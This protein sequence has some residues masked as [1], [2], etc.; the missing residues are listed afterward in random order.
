MH[1]WIGT[2]R[3]KLMSAL[4]FQ[5]SGFGPR[6]MWTGSMWNFYDNVAWFCGSSAWFGGENCRAEV[7]FIGQWSI[8]FWCCHV[9]FELCFLYG[10]RAL[11]HYFRIFRGNKKKKTHFAWY[12]AKKNLLVDRRPSAAKGHAIFIQHLLYFFWRIHRVTWQILATNTGLYPI[13]LL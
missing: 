6:A 12:A 11:D 5:P 8:S 9:M 10:S 1:V 4:L 3:H 13:L 7:V 2:Q